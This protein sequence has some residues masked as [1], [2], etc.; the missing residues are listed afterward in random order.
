MKKIEKF[1][2]HSAAYTVIISALFFLFAKAFSLA[3]TSMSFGRYFLILMFGVIISAS[4]FIF[5]ID[6]IPLPVKYLVHFVCLFLTFFLVFMNVKNA[7]GA[8]H[9]S[10]TFVFSALAIFTVLYVI[11]LLLSKL[12]KKFAANEK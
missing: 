6:R 8:S 10:A 1:L 4:E 5:T 9:F 7:D 3:D 2:Y 11:I 12:V